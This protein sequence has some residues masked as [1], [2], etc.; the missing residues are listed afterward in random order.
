V[1]RRK[2]RHGGRKAGTRAFVSW[3]PT[4]TPQTPLRACGACLAYRGAHPGRACYTLA[5]V[6]SN[7]RAA[8]RAEIKLHAVLGLSVSTF[9]TRYDGPYPTLRE[10]WDYRDRLAGEHN[11]ADA[12]CDACGATHTTTLEFQLQDEGI[13]HLCDQCIT[14]RWLGGALG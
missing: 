9:V 11:F 14:Q 7:A 13:T 5:E 12:T 10:V 3:S 6:A 2:H 1:S 4:P 8:L